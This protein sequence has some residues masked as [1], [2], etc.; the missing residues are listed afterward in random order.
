[1]AFIY[2]ITNDINGK[3]YIGKTSSSID[4]RF[5][6]HCKES[7]GRRWEHRPLYSAMRKYGTQH[8]YVEQVE[9]CDESV[10]SEREVYWIDFYNS[11]HNGYNATLG[12]EGK[13]F[14]DYDEI[15]RLYK[16]GLSLG[17]I[18]KKIGCDSS[19]SSKI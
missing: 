3:V 4:S 5:Q 16:D 15:Y 2:K 19:Q 9:E 7:H 6:E 8:F 14:Y 17:E 18:K 11:Y 1:M 13:P 10:A 12:G